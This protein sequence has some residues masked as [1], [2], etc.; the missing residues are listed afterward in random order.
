MYS[1]ALEREMPYKAYLPRGY[2]SGEERYPVLYM[3]HGYGGGYGEWEHYGL[4]DAATRA[5]DAGLVPPM[6]I[7]TPEGDLGYWM[8]HADDG[9][10]YGTYAGRDVLAHIDAEYRTRATR[11]S[12]AI[13][14]LSMGADGALDLAFHN[15]RAFSIIGAHSVVLR[16]KSEAP[17]FFGDRKYFEAYDPMSI[18][19]DYGDRVRDADFTIW[20]DSGETDP[21]LPRAQAL[22]ALLRA[23]GIPH[24]WRLYGGDHEG[25]Y[26]QA[27]LDDYLAFYGEA[28]RARNPG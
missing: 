9:P 22:E 19:R 28:F 1:A 24:E 16:T 14:G 7:V 21:W 26:W 2:D 13:G 5:I 12:R 11:A 23:Q 18:V 10:R 25:G 20:L 6:I 3:L 15:A 17:Y 8:D 27:H 4:F